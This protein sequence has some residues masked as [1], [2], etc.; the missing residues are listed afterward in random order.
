MERKNFL[1]GWLEIK[2]G[3]GCSEE[4]VAKGKG[5][6]R[7]N[8]EETTGTRTPHDQSESSALS[9]VPVQRSGTAP[10]PKGVRRLLTVD[11]HRVQLRK[12]P[13]PVC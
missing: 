12:P 13:N 1:L 3:R 4:V 8:R 6:A 7:K 2:D 9:S 11:S 10:P 5:H